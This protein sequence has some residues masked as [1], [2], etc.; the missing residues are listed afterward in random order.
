MVYIYDGILLSLKKGNSDT[1]FT[2]DEPW[3]YY[4]K[5]NK[6][7]IKEQIWLYAVPRVIKFIETE[8]RMV[9]ARGWGGG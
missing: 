6:P 5:W 1:Y 2:M 9:P 7:V 3:N 4:T 8:G